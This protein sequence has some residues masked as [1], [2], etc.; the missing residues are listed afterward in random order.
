MN[1]CCTIKCN[2]YLYI[3]TE[4]YMLKYGDRGYRYILFEAGHC[5]Q[6]MNL[7]AEGLDLAP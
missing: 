6:N 2:C 3:G 1:L 4:G 7:I 5:F